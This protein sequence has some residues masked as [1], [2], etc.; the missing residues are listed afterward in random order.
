MTETQI[1]EVVIGTL[2]GAIIGNII[3]LIIARCKK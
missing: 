2:A 1:L 3:G